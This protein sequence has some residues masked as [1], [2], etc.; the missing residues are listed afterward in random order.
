MKKIM[1]KPE[2]YVTEM[3]KGIYKVHG[4]KLTFVDNDVHCLVSA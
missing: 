3:L 2:D 1:N 4:K